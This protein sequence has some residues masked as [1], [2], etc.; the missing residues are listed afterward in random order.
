MPE[1]GMLANPAPHG[2]HEASEG[3]ACDGPLVDGVASQP[4]AKFE[5]KLASQPAPK[6]DSRSDSPPD[7]HSGLRPATRYW[8]A[9]LEVRVARRAAASIAV[10]RR[11]RGPLRLQKP[12]YPEGPGVAHLLVVHP[13]AGIAGGDRL[14]IDI[15]VSNDAHALVT[16]PGA[17]KWYRS[18]GA[19]AHQHV[20]L[21]VARGA[22]L[23]WLPPENIVFDGADLHTSTTIACERG[24]T[25]IGW[26][27]V[28]LGRRASGERFEEGAVRQDL[29][30]SCDDRM[31]WRERARLI[32]ADA[33]LAS[34]TGWSGRAVAGVLWAWGS[35]LSDADLER[36][37]DAT[38]ARPDAGITVLGDGLVVAR[39][40]SDSAERVRDLF[41]ELWAIIR[42]AMTARCA[43]R[44]RIWAT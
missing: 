25:C 4:E 19:R 15:D 39:A 43:I 12:L 23:E 17:T 31:L 3:R 26:D 9:R 29:T 42:P 38:M 2:L 21:T 11:H 44:P 16:M 32:G 18:D 6:S 35:A 40:L 30:L 24:A 33:L 27:I 10:H 20:A 22:C 1:S 37:R 41:H 34:R 13:P 7:S 8:N 14:E 5:A 36:C 28:V